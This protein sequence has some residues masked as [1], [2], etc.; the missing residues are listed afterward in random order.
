MTDESMARVARRMVSLEQKHEALA[1]ARQL[2]ASSVVLPD[3]TTVS[4]GQAAET[5]VDAA[6]G[7]GAL[8]GH[9]TGLGDIADRQAGTESYVPGWIG[10]AAGSADAGHQAGGIAYE[11]ARDAQSTAD[12]A[13]TVAEEN[14]EDLLVVAQDA[15]D[16]REVADSNIS[17]IVDEYATSASPTVPPTL[18]WS[19]DPPA[20]VDGVWI[21]VRR[22]TVTAGGGHTTGDPVLMTGP[23][24]AGGRGVQSVTPLYRVVENLAPAILG[25]GAWAE[26]RRNQCQNPRLASALTGWTAAGSFASTLARAAATGLEGASWAATATASNTAAGSSVWFT[27]ASDGTGAAVGFWARAVYAGASA[28]VLAR[29]ATSSDMNTAVSDSV[30]VPG[31]GVWRWYSLAVTAGTAGTRYVGV[32]FSAGLTG[33][34]VQVSRGLYIPGVS[35][36]PSASEFF[37]GTS[38]DFTV[39]PDMRTRFVGTVDGSDSL[40]QIERVA[41]LSALNCVVGLSTWEGRP[42]A[43]LIP[44]S[45]LTDTAAYLTIPEPL[46]GDGT[47]LGTVHLTAPL[48]GTT[49]SDL[50]ARN[51]VAGFVA[52]VGATPYPV[53]NVAGSYPRRLRLT[54]PSNTSARLYHGGGLGSGE[55]RWADP[56][57]YAGD[58]LDFTQ[59]SETEPAFAQGLTLWRTERIL[60]TDSTVEYTPVTAVQSWDGVSDGLD[61][62][63]VG[64]AVEYAVGGPTAPTTGWQATPP[65]RAEGQTLWMRVATTYGDGTVSRSAAA[66]VTGDQGDQ[67]D[68]GDP[69]A[70]GTSVTTLTRFYYL[71]ATEPAV[72]TASPPPAPWLTTEPA[73][74][75]GSSADLWEVT[76]T[77]LST[78]A[79]SYGPVSKS[80]AFTAAKQAFD[81]AGDALFLAE[82]IYTVIPSTTEPTTR[83]GGAPL[84]QGDLWWQIGT[85]EHAGKF[86]GVSV[87]SGSA[88][89]PRQMVADMILVPS[90]V[91]PV[92]IAAGAMTAKIVEGDDIRTAFSGQRMQMDGGGLH[93][94]DA[95]DIER[96]RLWSRDGSLELGGTL[97]LN[98]SLFGDVMARGTFISPT[99][100]SIPMTPGAI[101]EVTQLTADYLGGYADFTLR[102]GYFV[103]GGPPTSGDRTLT[104]LAKAVDVVTDALT[105]NSRPVAFAEAAGV[106]ATAPSVPAAGNVNTSITFPTG[107]FTQPPIVVVTAGNA[108]LT[109]S[110][111]NV[112]ATSFTLSASNWSPAAAAANIPIRWHAVQMTKA[113]AAG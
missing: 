42:M 84:V 39:D 61:L 70:Q 51:L 15:H 27:V 36:A 100:V 98:A 91:G 22:T 68:Q 7:V 82:G 78:G 77:L 62:T 43:R 23:A 14:A 57:L 101:S 108:R 30:S 28:G 95:A 111:E 83:P 11:R 21:W 65:A 72:P 24:G 63:V 90:S 26:V 31:D 55:V 80:A 40:M 87:W 49:Q 2:P 13:K 85:D 16:A 35:R 32:R 67:G 88:W 18:G 112:T 53:P 3:G 44:T 60:Y 37:D 1:R 81:K 96:A 71:S 45:A 29:V 110:A 5:A 76:R 92:L 20:W 19:S 58:V 86:I 56:G 109:C 107:R 6:A 97:Q 89:Q 103:P 46:R 99:M 17:G 48:T 104:L 113:A 74:T 50:R 106:W 102:A 25:S 52:Q 105:I 10:G 73:Y 93:A 34:T 41:G 54:N 66:P 38:P 79:W 33:A 4:V 12:D 64:T 75:P 47:I 69:G 8:D 94:F 9:V 59:W